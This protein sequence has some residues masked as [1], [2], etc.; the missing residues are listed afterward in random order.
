MT[1]VPAANIIGRASYIYWSGFERIGL[2]LK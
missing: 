1:A 2:A